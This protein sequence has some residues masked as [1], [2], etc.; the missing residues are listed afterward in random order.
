VFPRCARHA[1][2]PLQ[3]DSLDE[4]C[5]EEEGKRKLV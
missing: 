1:E 3:V 2:R 5:G 4:I